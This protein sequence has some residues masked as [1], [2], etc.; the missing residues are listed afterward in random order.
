MSTVVNF[1]RADIPRLADPDA[2]ALSSSVPP[3]SALRFDGIY[4]E[5]N[6]AGEVRLCSRLEVIGICH[7]PEG[8]GYGRVIEITTPTRDI[9]S[10]VIDEVD[11]HRSAAALLGPLCD[12]ELV[13]GSVPGG[14][15]RLQGLLQVWRPARFILRVRQAG[16]VNNSHASYVLPTGDVVGAQD[17]VPDPRSSSPPPRQGG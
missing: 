12:A 14:K 7:R 17:V 11:V 8:G 2:D 13:L 5:T 10:L 4:I 9:V 15:E 3:G 16:W 6:D 1:R